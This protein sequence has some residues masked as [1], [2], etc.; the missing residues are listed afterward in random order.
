MKFNCQLN[1]LTNLIGAPTLIDNTKAL[2]NHYFNCSNNQLTSLTGG[3]A[4][5]GRDFF[6]QNNKLTS[7][8]HI[9]KEIKRISR[10]FY[11]NE[12]PIKEAVL[13][14]LLIKG[15]KVVEGLPCD[16]II[17]KYLPNK[18]GMEAVSWCQDELIEAGFEEFAEL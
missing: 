5:A 17:N 3:P 18:K 8:H 4:N 9:H 11:C 15:L 13:G 12:N 6:C 7:L 16:D 1:Q 10:G 14:L 2:H